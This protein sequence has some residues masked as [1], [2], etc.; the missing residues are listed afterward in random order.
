MWHWEIILLLL[1]VGSAAGFIAGLF[2]VGGG[3]LIVPVV[4]WVLGYQ[5]LA[6]H[7]YAQHLAVGTSLPLWS[8]PPSP[9]CWGSTKNRRLTGKRYS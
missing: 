2:G 1:S 7:P 9:V 4:L 8:L 3:T 6:Q 5:G